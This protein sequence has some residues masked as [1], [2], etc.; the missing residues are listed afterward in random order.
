MGAPFPSSCRDAS[1]DSPVTLQSS[2]PV[3][4]RSSGVLMEHGAPTVPTRI[5]A[6]APRSVQCTAR[7]SSAH[8]ATRAPAPAETLI[9]GFDP[10]YPPLPGPAPSAVLIRGATIWTSAAED[11]LAEGDLLARGGK[12]AAVGKGLEAPE[13]VR[14]SSTRTAST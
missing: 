14:S 6:A 13:A 9:A 2:S 11:T 10:P 4:L 5:P 12:I 7:T 3:T 1:P 8:C